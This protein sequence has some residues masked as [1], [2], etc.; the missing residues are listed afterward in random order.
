MMH[1]LEQIYDDI[2]IKYIKSTEHQHFL[3]QIYDAFLGTDI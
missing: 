3:G 1:F 2:D